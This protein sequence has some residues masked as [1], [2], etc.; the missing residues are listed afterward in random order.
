MKKMKDLTVEERKVLKKMFWNSH[1][2]FNNFN[3][4]KMEAN[5]FTLTMTPAIESIYKDEP[6]AKKE[7]YLRHQAFFNTHA[8]ALNYIAGMSYALE[9]DYHDG[10]IPESTI[11]AI[12]VSLMGPTAGMFDS[13]FFNCLRVIAAGIGI[14]LCASGNFLG[15]ILFII[16]YGFTQSVCKYY[17]TILGYT[18][19]VE[20]IDRVY[21]SGLMKIA[22]K[23]ISIIGLLMVGAM[24]AVTVNFPLN[25][26]FSVGEKSVV[27]LDLLNAIYPGIM[28]VVLVLIC[29][30]LIKKGKRPMFLI[31]SILVLGLV[32]ALIGIF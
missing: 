16:I 1:R 11:N 2:V 13:L 4:T 9:Q 27:V 32:G 6:E 26:T 28:S 17:L 14:T 23:S 24:T 19:G 8:V 25:M 22:T 21:N 5:G 18:S 29:M 10:K 3:M 30:A 7:A 12:K 20:F 31:L 15:S